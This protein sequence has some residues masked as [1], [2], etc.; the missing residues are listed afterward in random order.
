MQQGKRYMSPTQ[1][2]SAKTKEK[3]A[4][5]GESPRTPP[6]SPGATKR[7]KE[8]QERAAI[9]AANGIQTPT[10]LAIAETAAGRSKGVYRVKTS[11]TPTQPQT[12]IH[13]SYS[14]T[15]TP[16]TPK[17][18]AVTALETGE[19]SHASPPSEL[20]TGAG[21]MSLGFART[22]DHHDP[23]IARLT[24]RTR[25][26][27]PGIS[28][29]TTRSIPGYAGSPEPETAA[30]P[31]SA[32]ILDGT[33]TRRARAKATTPESPSSLDTSRQPISA[34]LPITQ[35]PGLGTIIQSLSSEESSSSEEQKERPRP[36]STESE[37]GEAP[38][39]LDQQ[40]SHALGHTGLLH[41]A[42]V[43][44]YMPR[45]REP[46]PDD[47][48]QIG[49]Q[50]AST[51]TSE[52]MGSHQR[53]IEEDAGAATH[54]TTELDHPPVSATAATTTQS[55]TSRAQSA[56]AP[57]ATTGTTRQRIGSRDRGSQLAARTSTQTRPQVT[58]SDSKDETRPPEDTTLLFE[59]RPTSDAQALEADR[60]QI[61]R[62]D[63]S[64][65]TQ[66]AQ[67][68]EQQRARRILIRQYAYLLSITA[69][70]ALWIP[71]GG[72]L[73]QANIESY[74][75][76]WTYGPADAA[77]GAAALTAGDCTTGWS[78]DNGYP[79]MTVS[80]LNENDC[81]LRQVEAARSAA[82]A[83]YLQ[84]NQTGQINTAW[85]QGAG[86]G[87]VLAVLA[88]AW[89]LWPMLQRYRESRP[90]IESHASRRTIAWAAGAFALIGA[91][92]G[93]ALGAGIGAWIARDQG[94]IAGNIAAE[95][96]GP[97]DAAQN[98]FLA[99]NQANYIG[100][101]FIIGTLLGLFSIII[102]NCARIIQAAEHFTAPHTDSTLATQQPTG[103]R[104]LDDATPEALRD[105][106]TEENAYIDFTGAYFDTTRQPS[107]INPTARRL[108]QSGLH[109]PAIAFAA[110]QI[111]R[112]ETESPSDSRN[113][114]YRNL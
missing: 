82:A 56:F 9:R 94:A 98:N 6:M 87:A 72:A 37:E 24:S 15:G 54:R 67:T 88:I 58:G 33:G 18:T 27:H 59:D 49:G 48:A 50:E 44:S 23:I 60:L 91:L 76:L 51:G 63:R 110:A 11:D 12:A 112:E 22:P 36:L 66:S 35:R 104:T 25:Q 75:A 97:R 100:I 90:Q 92:L 89:A 108:V 106:P 46:L 3:S 65:H 61:I 101:D 43:T 21:V 68:P 42:G 20:P 26:L 16:E 10:A 73:V 70:N 1:A 45:S 71:I 93:G 85:R 40:L 69:L 31:A 80:A 55:I 114:A 32:E 53:P 29:D 81:N 86:A 52:S 83:L 19:S 34:W 96:N 95:L 62:Q 77:A 17:V 57:T 109:E 99:R 28:P 103:F 14:S 13:K 7:A 102:A 111:R 8:R 4:G 64:S 2:S 47:N 79:T 5:A 39:S 78:F 41:D 38:P 105:T 107:Y 113:G 30:A 74:L 84:Q